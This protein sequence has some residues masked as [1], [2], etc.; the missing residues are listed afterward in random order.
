MP[1]V[2]QPLSGR[3]SFQTHQHIFLIP[4]PLLKKKKKSRLFGVGFTCPTPWKWVYLIF[5]NSFRFISKLS[6]WYRGFPSIPCSYTATASLT[7]FMGFDKC[8]M[9]H[10]HHYGII[11]NAFIALILL[12]VHLLISSPNPCQPLIFLL[13]HSFALFYIVWIIH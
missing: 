7:H 13:L 1:K 10:I 3:D 11:Q 6:W 4:E 5:Q 9:T 8:I 12:C 2:T